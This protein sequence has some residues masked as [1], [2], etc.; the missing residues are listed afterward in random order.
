VITTKEEGEA[1]ISATRRKFSEQT[2]EDTGVARVDTAATRED[3]DREGHEQSIKRCEDAEE[4][5]LTSEGRQEEHFFFATLCFP[6]VPEQTLE[7][8]E[9]TS[10]VKI[11]KELPDNKFLHYRIRAHAIEDLHQPAMRPMLEDID[12]M[13][14]KYHK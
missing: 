14:E 3:M 7:E 6:G 4:R 2:I 5:H 1:S 9:S 12:E 8:G 13:I 11:A 10:I